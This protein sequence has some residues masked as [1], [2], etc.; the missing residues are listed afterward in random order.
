MASTAATRVVQAALD[1]ECSAQEL[2]ELAASDPA[3]AIKVLSLANS[4]AFR[5]KSEVHDVR[6]AAALLGVRGLRNLALS[7][8]VTDMAPPNE[9]GAAILASSLRR[10]LAARFIATELG[11]R[12]VDP[13]FTAG[14][15]LESGLLVSMTEDPAFTQEVVDTPAS[16]RVVRERAAGVVDHPSRGRELAESYHLPS[17]TI[18]AIAHHHDEACP[19]GD[20]PAIAWLAERV[21]AIYEGGDISGSRAKVEAAAAT[22]GLDES[23]IGRVIEQLPEAVSLAAAAFSRDVGEMRD[24]DALVADANRALVDLNAQYEGM[25]RQLQ[26]LIGQKES[27]EKELRETN[28]RL[29]VQATT[30]ELTG[31][32]NKRALQVALHRDMAQ[33]RRE[34]QTLSLVVIDIDHFKSF[35]DTWGHALGD[36]VLRVV[37]KTLKENVRTADLPARYGGEEFVII[38]PHTGKHSA[39]AVAER[40]RRALEETK[41]QG[42]SGPLH[43]TASFGIASS[44]GSDAPEELFVKADDALYQ[45][46]RSGRNRVCLA[47]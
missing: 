43:V 37:G 23:A 22:I 45:A 21:A 14:L 31:L 4:P 46:K 44:D 6:R 18:K 24:Y 38:L 41:V 40:V 32:P 27:L 17:S 13:F 20:T 28:E 26:A 1:P 36:E 19:E 12:E 35:N 2:G 39:K 7:L 8:V 16:F 25:V 33:A 34:N 29:A 10:A 9:L 3:F 5:L 11:H 30:D 42:P 47:A 15:F